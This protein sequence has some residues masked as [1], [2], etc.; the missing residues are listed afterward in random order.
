ME[1][2]LAQ[3]SVKLEEALERVKSIQQAVSVDLPHVIEVSFL[4]LSLTPSF[5][6]VASARLLLVLQGLEEMLSRKSRFLQMEHA[7]VAELERELESA[8][9]VSQDRAAEVTE[10]W[11]VELH[12]AEWATAT[13]RGFEAAKVL[14]AEIKVVL[15]KSLVE[16]EVAL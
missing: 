5:S 10:A 12:V 14:Q 15:Q 13:E 9:H 11:A 3:T 16:T 2:D 4:Y 7:R 1:S 8:R 6:S